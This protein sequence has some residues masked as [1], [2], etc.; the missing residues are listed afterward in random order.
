MFNSIAEDYLKSHP[1]Q[2]RDP[3]EIEKMTKKNIFG[4]DPLDI[5]SIIKGKI[6]KKTK[7]EPPASRRGRGRSSL[8]IRASSDLSASDD[9][10]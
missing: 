8:A 1:E 2:K 5:Q 10:Q 6:P 3:N 7:V 9:D 4:F